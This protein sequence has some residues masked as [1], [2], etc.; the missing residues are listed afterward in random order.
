[1]QNPNHRITL[2]D[3]NGKEYVTWAIRT[4]RPGTVF[5]AT[6][7]VV[8]AWDARF[9]IRRDEFQNITPDWILYDED[10]R[11]YSI[12]SVARAN[13][14]GRWWNLLTEAVQ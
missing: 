3:T 14:P 11:E 5:R 2:R 6:E 9:T 7:T 13:I 8:A 1:M 4:D 10:D 12:T